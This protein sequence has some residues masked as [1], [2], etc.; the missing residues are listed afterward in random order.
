MRQIL[1]SLSSRIDGIFGRDLYGSSATRWLV[2]LGT[3]VVVFVGLRVVKYVLVTRFKG[4]VE[5]TKNVVDDLVLDLI[6]HTKWPFFLIL[7]I[8]WGSFVLKLSPAVRLGVHRIMAV[9]LFIQVGLWASRVLSFFIETRMERAHREDPSR[10]AVLSLFNFFGRVTVWC[11][12][13]LLTLDNLGIDVTALIASLG[14]GGIALALA[15]QSVLKDTFA[16]LSIIIDKPVE[17]GDFVIIGDLAGHIEHIGLKTTRVR[18]LGGEELVFGNEDLLSSRIRN[19]KN[20]RERRVIF[21]F[22]IT[23]ETPPEKVRSVAQLVKETIESVE[24]TRFD[25]AYLKDFGETALQFQV[26]YYVL[27]PSFD[28]MMDVRQRINITL[29]ERFRDEGIRFAYPIRRIYIEG[30]ASS[31]P[32]AS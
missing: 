24:H 27:D 1:I 25:R 22:G 5:R 19:Y 9:S 28:T 11:I 12:V 15:L 26:A 7:G 4:V 32:L 3:L 23:Y 13:A 20:L 17:V 6:A 2:A 10:S 29:H 18:S 21:T 16:A 30:D 8:F 14:V 31:P